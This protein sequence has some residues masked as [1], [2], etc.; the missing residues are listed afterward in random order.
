MNE[1]RWERLGASMGIAFFVLMVASFVVA[2]APPKVNASLV[3]ITD[4]L[5]A[6]Y[7]R[8]LLGTVLAA[9]AVLAFLWFIG[10]LRHVLQRAEGGA[11]A[12]S[13]IVFGSGV[14]VAVVGMISSLPI[15][16]LAYAAQSPEARLN[17]LAARALGAGA[18]RALYDANYLAAGLALMTGALFLVAAGIAISIGELARPWLGWLALLAGVLALV[19]GVAQFFTTSTTTATMTLVLSGFIALA[20]WPA[21]AGIVMLY[22][23]EVERAKAPRAVFTH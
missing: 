4:Y 17:P 18:T 6:N 10:H 13:P 11:E 14:A 19:G 12:F 22:R 16:T 9:L 7:A 2:P 15:A 21:I 1:R 23:P 8:L 3:S 5:A 20:V